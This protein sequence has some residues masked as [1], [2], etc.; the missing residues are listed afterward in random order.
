VKEC[1]RV[2]RDIPIMIVIEELRLF[3][4][5]K[6]HPVSKE[7]I[8]DLAQGGR[9]EGY[10][11]LLISQKCQNIEKDVLSSLT[12]LFIM[13]H[14]ID[15]DIEYL[16]KYAGKGRAEKLPKFP[17]GHAF[18]INYRESGEITEVQFPLNPNK[19]GGDTV[20]PTPVDPQPLEIKGKKKKKEKHESDVKYMVIGGIVAIV[21]VVI[22]VVIIVYL[23]IKGEEGDAA[24]HD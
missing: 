21:V 22:T 5:Q 20:Q 9:S 15:Q 23:M 18:H 10:G 13:K 8:E 3:A 24:D 12:D 16:S 1:H 7:P 4:P 19:K 2:K 17:K 6:K 11:C 14:T